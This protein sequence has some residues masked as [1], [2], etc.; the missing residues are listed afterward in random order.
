MVARPE[1]KELAHGLTQTPGGTGDCLPGR[2]RA[3]KAVQVSEEAEIFYDKAVEGG[4]RKLSLLANAAEAAKNSAT[5]FR[6]FRKNARGT[7][8]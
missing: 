8:N 3:D 5:E 6:T 1:N 7:P 2:W 4:S